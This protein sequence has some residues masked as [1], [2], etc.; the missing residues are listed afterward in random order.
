MRFLPAVGMTTRS[1]VLEEKEERAAKAALSSFSPSLPGTDSH[2][3]RRE[4][5]K[6]ANIICNYLLIK[7]LNCFR[8]T[9]IP[10][11]ALDYCVNFYDI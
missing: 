1:I 4:E 9:D 10:Y 2:S 8:L 5:S 7:L 11:R 6:K 3:D